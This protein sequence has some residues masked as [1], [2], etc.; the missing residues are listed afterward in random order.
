MKMKLLLVDNY[1]VFRKGLAHLLESEPNIDVVSTSS[2]ASEVIEVMREHKPDIVLIDPEL[3]ESRDVISHI[4]QVVPKARIIVLTHSNTSADLLS[5][6]SAGAAGYILK[7]TKYESLLKIIT[8]VT[9]GKLVVD[10]SMARLVADVFKFIHNHTHIMIKPEHITSLTEQ[11]KAI[12]ALLTKNATN[13]EIASSLCVTDNTVK[14]HV[15]NIMHKLRARNRLE[16]AI[17]AIQ[18]GLV[19]RIYETR[20]KDS[21]YNSD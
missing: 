9:E 6:M 13:K 20:G 15:R 17:C 18:A 5:T 2:T 4:Q 21:T 7:D 11:E 16:A 14:V 12:L 10:Q 8:L 3:F 19:P 1:E